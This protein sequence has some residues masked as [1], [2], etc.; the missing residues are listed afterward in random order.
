MTLGRASKPGAAA[1]RALA[2]CAPQAKAGV[3]LW[4]WIPITPYYK[5]IQVSTPTLT[6]PIAGAGG[7]AP[8]AAILNYV[9]PPTLGGALTANASADGK[10]IILT[11]IDAG[12]I[13]SSFP[14]IIGYQVTYA[15]TFQRGI[16][17]LAVT[18][19]PLPKPSGPSNTIA[20][21][22]QLGIPLQ[23]QASEVLSGWT[24]SGGL[25]FGIIYAYIWPL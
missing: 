10:S 23:F 5:T 25:Q 20:A 15:G 4:G 18:A 17:T 7:T 14:I 21:V 11:V 24:S 8:A 12:Q 13:P 16:G 19:P 6:V 9:S 22:P 1:D 2:H 3:G